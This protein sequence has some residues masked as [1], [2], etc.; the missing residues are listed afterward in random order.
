M[1]TW[2]CRVRPYP[3]S[4][5][6]ST[7]RVPSAAGPSSGHL[8]A[9]L[10]PN[11]WVE[12]AP[13]PQSQVTPPFLYRSSKLGSTALSVDP[14]VGT[15]FKVVPAPLRFA[16]EC[17]LDFFGPVKHEGPAA[18]QLQKGGICQSMTNAAFTSSCQVNYYNPCLFFIGRFA[19]HQHAAWKSGFGLLEVVDLITAY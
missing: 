17:V 4:F 2:R 18:C 15:T 3:R 11:S 19:Y 5:Q 8:V 10:L 7:N 9:P 6:P 12:L 14:K 16:E 1:G 13:L